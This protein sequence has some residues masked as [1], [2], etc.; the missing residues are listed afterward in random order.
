MNT[1]LLLFVIATM[2]LTLSACSEQVPEVEDFY[3]PQGDSAHGQQV[4]IDF[5]CF[6]CHTIKDTDLPEPAF[7]APFVVELGGKV[8]RWKLRQLLTAVIY[9]TM[10]CQENLPSLRPPGKQRGCH[11]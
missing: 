7:A 2:F 6:Q 11:P 4:F 10:H 5:K 9:L 3:L 8:E 1:K